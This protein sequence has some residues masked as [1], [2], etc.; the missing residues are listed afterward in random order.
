[1]EGENAAAGVGSPAEPAEPSEWIKNRAWIFTLRFLPTYL[2]KFPPLSPVFCSPWLGDVNAVVE[3][4]RGRVGV[5]GLSMVG[6]PAIGWGRSAENLGLVAR[7]GVLVST[8][9][10][11]EEDAKH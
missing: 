3:W 7:R 5:E 11:E 10:L 9:L 6:D 4:C 1:M 2:P 8:F